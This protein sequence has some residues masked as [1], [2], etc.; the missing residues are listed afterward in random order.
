MSQPLD[1]LV[2]DWIDFDV[3]AKPLSEEEA[4][5]LF[6]SLWTLEYPRLVKPSAKVGHEIARKA[7]GLTSA[8][9]LSRRYAGTRRGSWL[10]ALRR[11]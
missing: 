11:R 3:L 5:F 10:A 4:L 6:F 9:A 7:K 2:F 8:L 1:I